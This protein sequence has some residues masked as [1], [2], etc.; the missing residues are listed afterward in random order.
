[1]TLTKC[2]WLSTT[3]SQT[4]HLKLDSPR[5]YKQFSFLRFDLVRVF[6]IVFIFED[7]LSILTDLLVFIVQLVLSKK[8]FFHFLKFSLLFSNNFIRRLEM[9]CGRIMVLPKRE[10]SDTQQNFL[11]QHQVGDKSTDFHVVHTF[12]VVK[13][14]TFRFCICEDMF[15]YLCVFVCVMCLCDWKQCDINKSKEWR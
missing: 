12:C 8:T 15:L 1:M 3:D 14:A 5:S 10:D 13:H 7:L 6:Q 9:L 4:G 2:P 11:S